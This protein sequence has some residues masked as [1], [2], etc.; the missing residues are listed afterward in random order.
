VARGDVL[1][2]H[3][4][5][6]GGREQSGRR[7]AVVVQTATAGQPLLIVVPITSNVAASRYSFSVRVEP[8]PENGLI[9]PSVVMVFQMRAIDRVRIIRKLGKMSSSDMARID[10]EIWRMLKPP[11]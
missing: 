2:V 10:T 5:P 11:K 1:L 6:S 3:L 4:P 8:S 9:V 7:P